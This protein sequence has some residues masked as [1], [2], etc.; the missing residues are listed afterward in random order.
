[1]K[2]QNNNLDKI[3]REGKKMSKCLIGVTSNGHT[4][5]SLLGSTWDTC[6]MA[7]GRGHGWE[8]HFYKTMGWGWRI[9]QQKNTEL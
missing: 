2:R 3:T 7:R 5:R 9:L 1:M 4:I 6:P 8:A